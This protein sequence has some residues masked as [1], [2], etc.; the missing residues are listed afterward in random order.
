[1]KHELNVQSR[2]G[3]G[4]GDAR[5]LRKQ[6]MIPAVI[7]S[8]GAEAET[9]AL[10]AS[11]WEVLSRENLHLITLK[12]GDQSK[13]V[14]VKE[15][16]HDFIRNCA[17]HIDFMEVRGDQKI[18]TQVALR[19]GHQQPAGITAGGMLEQILHEV[20][21]E[22]VPADLPEEIV[23]DLSA[24]KLGEQLHVSAIALPEGVKM[25]TPGELT[26]FA[27]VDPNAAADAADDSEGAAEPEVIGEK[28]RAERA[29]AKAK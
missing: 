29:A 1:M 4:S 12:N 9:V 13:L 2:S 3:K 23:V 10:S 7:Y 19:A 24:L 22:C 20:Q 28:E 21:I 17:A 8:K 16:Q 27:V 14:L 26:A 11:E 6:G 25:L 5:R 18:A 15:V